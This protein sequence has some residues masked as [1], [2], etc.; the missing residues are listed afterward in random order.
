MKDAA[1]FARSDGAQKHQ[2][3]AGEVMVDQPEGAQIAAEGDEV[4]VGLEQVVILHRATQERGL[5]VVAQGGP[6][7]IRLPVDHAPRRSLASEP[8][9]IPLE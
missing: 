7:P 9:N 2:P 6:E 5:V 4:E 8:I 1:G 3:R